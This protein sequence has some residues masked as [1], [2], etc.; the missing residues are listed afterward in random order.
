MCLL[1]TADGLLKHTCALGTVIAGETRE[2]W[3]GVKRLD[4]LRRGQQPYPAYHRTRCVVQHRCSYAY[5]AL[6]AKRAI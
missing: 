2:G 1:E 4:T 3:S 6:E 5:H